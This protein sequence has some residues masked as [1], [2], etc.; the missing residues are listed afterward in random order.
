MKEI[1]K[2]QCEICKKIYDTQIEADACEAHGPP[3]T[4]LKVGDIVKTGT[5]YGWF[6]GQRNWVIGQKTPDPD[7]NRLIG[8][9]YVITAIDVD[10]Q[11]GHRVRYHLFTKAMTG[12]QGHDQGYTYDEHYKPIKVRNPPKAV[13]DSSK[14]LIGKKSEWLM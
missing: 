7:N 11:D 2:Y 6:D 12:K 3:T 10:L 8:F 13:V 9:Y 1:T 4:K 14:A 5:A